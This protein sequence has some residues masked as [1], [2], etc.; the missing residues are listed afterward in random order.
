MH[1]C[2][3]VWS[4]CEA[5]F[6]LARGSASGPPSPYPFVCTGTRFR[7][8]APKSNCGDS[9]WYGSYVPLPTVRYVA[10]KCIPGC[11]YNTCNTGTQVPVYP[12][13]GT[14]V[15]VPVPG[16]PYRY[17]C[18]NSSM[19]TNCNAYNCNVVQGTGTPGTGYNCRYPGTRYPVC[20]P[21]R[22]PRYLG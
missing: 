8:L 7:H 15:P 10:G 17:E 9:K 11:R 18:H 22:Y 1:I 2:G 19:H 4:S 16:Y 5:T 12:D 6:A 13:T 14:R 3:R 20:I 21:T